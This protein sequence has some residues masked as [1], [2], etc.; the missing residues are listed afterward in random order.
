M[1]SYQTNGLT[2]G[3]ASLRK[4][5]LSGLSHLIC[6]S[7]WTHK[8]SLY[9]APKS[10]PMNAP[11]ALPRFIHAKP[12]SAGWETKILVQRGLENPWSLVSLNPS[13]DQW[14]PKKERVLILK[15][16]CAPMTPKSS[17]TASCLSPSHECV[18]LA[19]SE[20]W[21]DILRRNQI[22]SFFERSVG[23]PL[24]FRPSHPSSSTSNF[25]VAC[26]GTTK[27]W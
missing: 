5:A 8:S 14:F 17:G 9:Q 22:G 23:S 19:N 2:Q 6:Q 4:R 25:A 13:L 26:S 15:L 21:F 27:T 18:G 11:P 10:H 3:E 16:D 1:E 12:G 7:R 20:P 24:N